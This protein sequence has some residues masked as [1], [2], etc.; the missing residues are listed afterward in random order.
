MA[1]IIEDV[2]Y[3]VIVL[4]DLFSLSCL[5]EDLSNHTWPQFSILRCILI[6]CL[7]DYLNNFILEGS[8]FVK[9]DVLIEPLTIYGLI[10]I[11][12]DIS[13]GSQVAHFLF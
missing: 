5:S 7:L 1:V 3:S 4:T 8:I 9:E 10:D 11:K 6:E 13:V 12:C 2:Y